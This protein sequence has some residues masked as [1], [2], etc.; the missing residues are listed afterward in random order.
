MN[1]SAVLRIAARALL[2]NRLRSFLTAL[3]I[4]I[5]TGAVI[6]MVSIGEGAKARV[7]AAFA[8]TGTNLLVVFPGSSTTGG[9]RGGGGTQPTLTWD[10]WAAIRTELRSVRLSA[11]TLR[12][13]VSVQSEQQNWTTLVIGTTQDYLDIRNWNM[14]SGVGLTPSDVDGSAK[15]AILGNTV[16]EKLFGASVDPVGQSIRIRN[17]PFQI[18]GVME[19]KGQSASG[20]DFDDSI[21]IPYSTFRSKVN[22]SPGKYIGGQIFIGVDPNIGTSRAVTEVTALLRDRHRI[23]TGGEDDFSVRD[24]VEMASAQAAGTETLSTLLAAIASVS[25]IVGGIGIM[26]TMLVSVMERTR[27]IG[28]RAAVG[29][30]PRDILAQFL[31]EAVLLSLLGGLAGAALGLVVAS[32]LASQLGW[33]MVVRGDIVVLA[34]GI[35]AAVGIGFGMYP[36]LRAARLDPIAA[37]RH[38]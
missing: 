26:N 23:P 32:Q 3:G 31:A 15:V 12:S 10:D 33:S 22:Q 16:V 5:G 37:L 1:F 6:A 34:I 13:T 7:E 36:A 11:P 25:L 27:E 35:S 29:A 9:S 14:A 2:R 30:R 24:P 4:I 38:E 21:F 19:K 17:I 8:S 18:I 20:A 28:I